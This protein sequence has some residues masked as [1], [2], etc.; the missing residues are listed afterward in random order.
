[1][2]KLTKLPEVSKLTNVETQCRNESFAKLLT[3]QQAEGNASI[4]LVIAK[5]KLV[6]QYNANYFVAASDVDKWYAE[7][8]FPDLKTVKKTDETGSDEVKAA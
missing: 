2:K 1:M 5:L 8:L 4:E 3:A 6:R 7:N